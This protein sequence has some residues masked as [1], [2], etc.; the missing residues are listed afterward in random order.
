MDFASEYWAKWSHPAACVTTSG[1]ESPCCSKRTRAPQ[2][3]NDTS[4]IGAKGILGI[5]KTFESVDQTPSSVDQEA[6]KNSS[7][8]AQAL[9]KGHFLMEM[10]PLQY[11]NVNPKFP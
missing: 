2:Y 10:P 8:F 3:Y 9:S 1:V 11:L 5:E 7:A 4:V 6:G